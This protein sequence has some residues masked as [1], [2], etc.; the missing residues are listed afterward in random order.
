MLAD[1]GAQVDKIEDDGAGDYL[2]WVEPQRGG[3]SVA[4]AALNR[5][6]RSA[7]MNL[8][9][10]AGREAFERLVGHYDVLVEQFRPGV[11]DRLGLGHE[12]LLTRYPRLVICALTGYGQDGPLRDRAGH[13]INYLA[14]GGLLGVQGPGGGAPPQIPGFQLAD[15]SGGMWVAIAVL[16]ALRR[17]DATGE[18]GVSDIAMADGLVGFASLSLPRGL[19]GEELPR[20]DE[21]LS[22]GAAAYNTYLAKD[23]APMT[24]GSLE[25]KF[26][27]AF[28]TANG[29]EPD[30]SAL[31][32]GPHQKALKEKLAAV[33]ASRTRPEWEA[34]ARE[35]DCCVEPVIPAHEL[36]ADEQL[37]A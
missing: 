11:L 26:W 10:P 17:R 6:K 31:V 2:R 32:P 5:G 23:G 35:H 18:G 24:L 14:R 20:G 15:V 3:S 8:K 22:G 25:P 13:D 12:R 34:F 33:F 27:T 4:F 1:L 19:L 29:I 36:L 28:A 9:A 37:R 21:V 30:L 7:V 16:G